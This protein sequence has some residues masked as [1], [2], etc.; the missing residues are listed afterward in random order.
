MNM[1]H[2]EMD[3]MDKRMRGLETRTPRCS[4]IVKDRVCIVRAGRKGFLT[5]FDDV[6]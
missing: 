1:M 6:V 3:K 2:T 5:I 4:R